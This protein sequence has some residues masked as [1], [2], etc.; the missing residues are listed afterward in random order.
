MSVRNDA[1]CDFQSSGGAEWEQ[2]RLFFAVWRRTGWIKKIK[3]KR[4]FL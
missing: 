2:T 1:A 3:K 4:D